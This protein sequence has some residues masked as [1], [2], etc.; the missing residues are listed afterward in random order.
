M[1]DQVC[2]K[3]ADLSWQ[4]IQPELEAQF[5]AAGLPD[6]ARLVRA[7]QFEMQ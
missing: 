4:S 3:P 6:L 2:L 1:M 5:Q 7:Q